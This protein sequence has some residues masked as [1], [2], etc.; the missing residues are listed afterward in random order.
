MSSFLKKIIKKLKKIGLLIQTK[1]K[2]F[3]FYEFNNYEFYNS[4]LEKFLKNNLKNFDKII[5]C[6]FGHGLFNNKI[7]EILEKNSNFCV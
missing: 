1:R 7:V 2:F 5:V 6:D 3:E 4:R